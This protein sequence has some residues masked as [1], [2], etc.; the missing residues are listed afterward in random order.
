MFEHCEKG[1]HSINYK[2]VQKKIYLMATHLIQLGQVKKE[3]SVLNNHLHMPIFCTTGTITLHAP[4][5]R[6]LKAVSPS[7]ILIPFS[8]THTCNAYIYITSAIKL[9]TI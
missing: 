5:I 8:E 3:N 4:I 2:H 1:C 6:S 7:S 9:I